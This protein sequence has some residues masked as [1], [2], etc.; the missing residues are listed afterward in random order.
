V[1]ISRWYDL[2]QHDAKLASV[3]DTFKATFTID[4]PKEKAAPAPAAAA[5]AAAPAAEK[6]KD[7]AAAQGKQAGAAAAGEKKEKP[8]KQAGGDKKEAQP[9]KGGKAAAAA[10]AT[11]PEVVDVSRID[12][13]V[14]KIVDCKKHP[15]AERLYVEQIDLGEEKPRTIVSGLAD[16]VP[17]DQM[18]G[19]MVVVVCNLKP[20]KLKGIESQGMVIAG[21]LY[22]AFKFSIII[23]WLLTV[24]TGF[25]F[26][27]VSVER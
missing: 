19:R 4:L 10:A 6:K 25:F 3:I 12:F 17:L 5:A 23:E 11:T 18:Q 16:F 8:A 15:D 7:G 24:Q 20:S 22:D 26:F 27:F 1:N 9:A 14:G 2:I 13:R 21:T